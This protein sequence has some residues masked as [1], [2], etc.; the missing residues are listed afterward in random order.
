MQKNKIYQ[1][2]CLAVL[3]TFRNESID[4]VVT[5]P[6][7]W[8]LRDYGVAGQLGM[9][10]N[11]R[12]YINNLCDIFDEI[13]RVLK[14]E[15]TV[16]VN[17]GDTY[18]SGA[19]GSRDTTRW[20]KQSRN[21]NGGKV[22]RAG[23]RLL[24]HKTLLQLPSR[25]AIEMVNRGW[26]LR[27]EIIWHKTNCMPQSAKDR[28][29]VDFEKIFFFVKQREYYFDQ[30][31]EKGTD[32]IWKSFNL[33]VWD[34]KKG[35]IKSAQYKATPAEL[36]KK[37]LANPTHLGTPGKRNMRSIWPIANRPSKEAHF[38]IFPEDLVKTP[39]KAGCPVGGV[40]LDPFMGS[41]TTAV[42]ARNLGRQYI[43]IELNPEYITIA[44]KRLAQQKII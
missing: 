31:K 6:P 9:E 10:P 1:G 42:V 30:Q 7:Y 26:I 36:K 28:F 20:P 16:W 14:R 41:G 38:A 35:K 40:I 24:P 27:N 37:Y 19:P 21:N 29:T 2:D 17:M 18:N 22:P 11:F 25:F 32:R 13:W 34:V 12:D 15:G 3:K 4:C 33:R 43:G 44:K 23:T 5:S 39:I 8:A